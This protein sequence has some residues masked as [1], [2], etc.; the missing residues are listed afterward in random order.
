MK[1]QPQ[2]I[3]A[4]QLAAPPQDPGESLDELLGPP[5]MRPGE[6]HERY[7]GSVSATFTSAAAAR[8]IATSLAVS[9][10]CERRLTICEMQAGAQTLD[11]IDDA[12]RRQMPTRAVSCLMSMYARTLVA[13]LSGHPVGAPA[14]GP[15]V[16]CMRLA[17]RLRA[18]GTLVQLRADEIEIALWWELASV[19]CGATMTEWALRQ[20]LDGGAVYDSPAARHDTAAS[21]AAR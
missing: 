14:S 8:G 15:P 7:P 10:V 6:L 4:L 13:A 11:A 18:A 20:L 9:V 2:N 17:N 16:I 3:R 5:Q 1:L 21:S 19:A 12:A